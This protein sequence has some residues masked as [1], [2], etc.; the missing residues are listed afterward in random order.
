MKKSVIIALSMILMVSIT[1]CSLKKEKIVKKEKKEEIK[2]LI[3]ATDPN[4]PPF[5]YYDGNNIKGIDVEI[6]EMIADELDVDFEIKDIKF[7]QIFSSLKSG[8]ANI[9]G[10]GITITDERKKKVG[11]TVPYF[12]TKIVIVSKEGSDISEFTRI[13]GKRVG[14]QKETV[15]DALITKELGGEKITRYD[16]GIEAIEALKLG[17]IECA[18]MDEVEAQELI[19]DEIGFYTIDTNYPEQEYA[20]AFDK[21][22]SLAKKVDKVIKKLQEDGSIEEIIK[23]YIKTA[24]MQDDEISVEDEGISAEETMAE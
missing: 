11:F 8:R 20:F 2:S 6:A 12:K 1:G 7:E 19:K 18:I 13:L 4:F 23:A 16:K 3:L 5:T 21:K 22:S 14:V 24:E 17:E 15:G 10:S 9:A